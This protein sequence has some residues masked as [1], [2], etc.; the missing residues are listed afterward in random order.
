M[1]ILDLYI[2]HPVERNRCRK[3]IKNMAFWKAIY[4][5]LGQTLHALIRFKQYIYKVFT[6]TRHTPSPYQ[7]ISVH[8]VLVKVTK[9]KKKHLEGLFQWDSLENSN[10]RHIHIYTFT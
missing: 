5:V 6:L 10:N 9:L 7:S 4:Y 1:V 2:D 8:L 3:F